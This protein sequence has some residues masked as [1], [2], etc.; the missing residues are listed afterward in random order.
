MPPPSHWPAALILILA[1]PSPT[2]AQTP[3]AQTPL[4][5]TPL[6]RHDG[7]TLTARTVATGFDQPVFL[8]APPGD[9]RLFVVEKTGRIRVISDGKVLPQPFLDLASQVSTDSEQGLLGLA[10]HP[11]F[12]ANQRFFVYFTDPGGTITIAEGQASVT[13]VEA[14]DLAA[15]HVV[16][17]LPHDQAP[18]HNGGWL[19]FGPDGYLYIGTGDGGGAGDRQGNA[20][21]PDRLLGKILR[22]DVEDPGNYTIPLANLFAKGGGAPEIFALGLRNPWR[23][24]FDG[25]LLYIG[26]VG[27][28]AWEEVNVLSTRDAGANLG[29]NRVEGHACFK[30]AS[31]DATGLTPPVHVYDHALGC[32]I[33]GGY[34][35]RGAAMPALQGRYFF[36]DFCSGS[37]MSFRLRDG[38][39]QDFVGPDNGLASPGQIESFGQITSFGQD[40][41]GELYLLTLDGTIAKLVS[42]GN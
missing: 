39:A 38:A 42:T 20:Q 28:G 8:T 19:G 10:F 9:P 13:E 21:N 11:D 17:T 31:C 18:N 12:S 32:S 33:T 14:S 37:L 6:S 34:V 7:V 3:L 30:S 15:L 26:D 24:A 27:Q 23:A 41:A 5:Q 29:W 1:L 36:S 2:L 4:A 16:L 25:D 22:I 40:A 35:Y